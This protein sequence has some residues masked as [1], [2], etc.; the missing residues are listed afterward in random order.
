M[1]ENNPILSDN[2]IPLKR[3]QLEKYLICNLLNLFNDFFLMMLSIFKTRVV[4]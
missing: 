4:V 2:Q 3:F 1:I